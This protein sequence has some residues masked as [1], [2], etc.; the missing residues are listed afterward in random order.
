VKDNEENKI[1]T[2][3]QRK[4][5][6]KVTNEMLS[7]ADRV[8]GK[9]SAHGKQVDVRVYCAGRFITVQAFLRG[10]A[11]DCKLEVTGVGRNGFETN[12]TVFSLKQPDYEIDSDDLQDALEFAL[13]D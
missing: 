4:I 10:K 1:I 13:R 6:D 11:I 9:V 3:W 2:G 7:F 12:R 8:N 5:L